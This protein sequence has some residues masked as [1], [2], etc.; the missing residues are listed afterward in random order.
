MTKI[1]AFAGSARRDSCNKKLLHVAAAKAQNAGAEVTL[2]D[3]RD[4]P[5]PLY[6]GDLEEADGLPANATKLKTLMRE[7]SGLFIACPECNSSI[8]PLLKNAIDWASL[9]GAFQA[10]GEDGS[11]V[12]ERTD[13]K[14]GKLAEELVAMTSKLH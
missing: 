13:G 8:T 9:P 10:F 12:D 7:H 2:I 5:M 4:L 3:L 11:L 1:L 14:V 6:G